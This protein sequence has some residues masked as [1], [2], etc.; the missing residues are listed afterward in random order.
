MRS[1]SS[2]VAASVKVMTNICG[3]IKGAPKAD[4]G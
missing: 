3:G 2:A 1:R 4:W